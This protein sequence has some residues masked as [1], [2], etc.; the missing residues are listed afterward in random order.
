MK[1]K[2]RRKLIGVRQNKLLKMLIKKRAKTG[3]TK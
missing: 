1:E 2:K 3:V